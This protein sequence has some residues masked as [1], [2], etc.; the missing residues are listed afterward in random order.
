MNTISRM[1]L[2][3]HTAATAA[4]ENQRL[5]QFAIQAQAD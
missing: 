2:L 4:T 3:Q 1:A 5:H